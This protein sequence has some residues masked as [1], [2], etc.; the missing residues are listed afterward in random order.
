LT[1]DDILFKKVRDTLSRRIQAT[2][3]WA[4]WKQYLGKKGRYRDGMTN[5]DDRTRSELLLPQTTTSA[6]V[7]IVFFKYRFK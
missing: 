5:S 1:L 3:I 2:S 6:A 7:R 4:R